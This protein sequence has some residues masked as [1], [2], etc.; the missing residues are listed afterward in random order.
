VRAAIEQFRRDGREKDDEIGRLR[1]QLGD[2]EAEL[3]EKEAQNQQLMTAHALEIET[4]GREFNE[5]QDAAVQYRDDVQG[6]IEEM[7]RSVD[8]LNDDYESR[9]ADL[10]DEVDDLN[11]R[12]IVLTGRLKEYESRFAEIRRKAANPAEL[13]DGEVIDTEPAND[14]VFINRGRKDRIVLGMT[15]EVYDDSNLI[16]TDPSTGF[17]SRGKASIQVV[18]VGESTSTCKIIRSVSGRPAI[19]N[20][21]IANAI[22]D[23]E[24]SFGFLVHGKFDVDRDG[25]PT[26]AEA[27]YLRALVKDWGGTVEY[28]EELPGDLD[29]LVLGMMP[30]QPS[31]L[32]PDATPIQIEIWAKQRAERE[33]Y[34]RLFRQASEAQIP[35]LNANRFFILIGR[36]DS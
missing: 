5:Y 16:R 32:P 15:F 4:I 9:I 31:P 11:R 25:K 34:M 7:R 19:R 22:Y 21:V 17:F 14:Q 33:K 27:D 18:K 36:P 2:R 3:T 12:A 26:E 10:E 20:D 23:P 1:A 28:G 30:P 24:Y 13:V 35:V 29:F 8:R 6:T